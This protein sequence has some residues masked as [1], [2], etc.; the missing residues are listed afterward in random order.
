MAFLGEVKGS[1]SKLFSG[2]PTN[3]R[4]FKGACG[5]DTMILCMSVHEALRSKN[6][7]GW[8]TNPYQ[9]ATIRNTSGLSQTPEVFLVLQIQLA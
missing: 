7:E 2:Q 5:V 3:N 4:G 9:R 6:V 1:P 8:L